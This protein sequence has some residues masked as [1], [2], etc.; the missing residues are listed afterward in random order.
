MP[1]TIQPATLKIKNGNAYY[2]A[3]SLKGDPGDIS[4]VA[5][6]YSDLTFPVAAGKLCTHDNALY[7]A[8]QTISTSEVWTAAHWTATTIEDEFSGKVDKVESAT[9]GNLPI[10]DGNGNLIDSGYK[11]SDYAYAADMSGKADKSGTVLDTTLSRGRKSGTTVGSQSMAFGDNVEASGTDSV[12]F[13]RNTIAKG[14]MQHVF[15]RYNVA[16][17]PSEYSAYWAAN[18]EYAAGAKV[19]N[20]GAQDLMHYYICIEAHTSGSTFDSSKWYDVPNYQGTQY[21]EIVGNGESNNARANARSLDWGGNEK[22][23]GDLTV[24]AGTNDE[25]S[26]SQLRNEINVM[27]PAATSSDIGKAL[28][29]KTVADGVPTS[30]E[31]GEAGGGTIDPQ[32]I[33]DAVDAWC[34]ENIT[35]PD[36]PP[37]DRSLSSM[38]AAAP[39]DMA[40][41]L[42]NEINHINT[43]QLEAKYSGSI[44]GTAIVTTEISSVPAGTYQLYIKK[45]TSTDTDYTKCVIAFLN[46][47]TSVLSETVARNTEIS[48]EITFASAVNK[49]TV[50]ASQTAAAATGDTVTVEGMLILSPSALGAR[51]N[52]IE[53]NINTLGSTVASQ[54]TTVTKLNSLVTENAEPYSGGWSQGYWT[55]P[56]ATWSNNNICRNTVAVVVPKNATVEISPNSQYILIQD[57]TGTTLDNTNFVVDGTTMNVSVSYNTGTKFTSIPEQEERK[58]F[59][60][61]AKNS[62]A[63]VAITPSEVAI[64]VK[65]KLADDTKEKADIG[66]YN[67]NKTPIEEGGIEFTAGS[68]VTAAGVLRTGFIPVEADEI[69]EIYSNNDNFN[70][71]AYVFEYTSAKAFIKYSTTVPNKTWWKMSSTTA[72]IRV[73]TASPSASYST[74]DKTKLVVA[75]DKWYRRNTFN[76]EALLN[77]HDFFSVSARQADVLP[78]VHASSKYGINSNGIKNRVKEFSM[79]ITTDVHYCGSAMMAAIDYLNKTDGIDCGICLGDIQSGNFGSNPTDWYT[80]AVSKSNKPFFTVMGNHDYG[81]GTS[82]STAGSNG[83]VFEA[84]IEPTLDKIGIVDLETIYYAKTFSDYGIVLIV[85]NDFDLPDTMA[86]ESNYLVARNTYNFLSQTQINW[87]ISTLANVPS[88][89]HVMIARHDSPSSATSVDCIWTQPGM[90][91][92]GCGA[93]YSGSIVPDIVN[94]WVNGTTL[95]QTYSPASGFSSLGDITVSADF[96]SRGTGAFIGYIEGHTHTDVYAHDATYSNQNVFVC[97][98]TANDLYQGFRNDLPRERGTKTDDCFTVLSVDKTNKKVKVVRVG[99]AITTGMTDRTMFTFTY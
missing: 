31:Y 68:A 46:G 64:T 92:E 75:V 48:K 28:L 59:I 61:V 18:T 57:G 73:R 70:D 97:A 69:Y 27:K 12:A 26:V 51:L 32:D 66:T 35:N 19:K 79:L 3:D 80:Y 56:S 91:A 81:E 82:T 54:G 99:S 13:G 89:Y 34:E 77:G 86:D 41:S 30:Y 83:E 76:E 90:N 22:L 36:S 96:S 63:N 84:F 14:Q 5:P 50:Y 42:K 87:L 74:P 95:S 7:K 25:T 20:R 16:D 93:I 53:S 55:S 2:S 85:L 39:A 45:V 6:D 52:T 43:D 11:P 40:G 29:V 15:G 21:L 67:I 62:S 17:D 88:G 60:R 37:L 33:A 4:I 38:S 94:A 72:Y 65:I 71:V 47:S 49:I 8:N 9:S 24:F 44:T 98:T 58:L 23:Q 10:L 78:H 1:I